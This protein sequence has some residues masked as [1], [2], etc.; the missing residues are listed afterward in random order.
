MNSRCYRETA[1]VAKEP[2]QINENLE[3]ENLEKTSFA[4]AA[5]RRSGDRRMCEV[6]AIV[7]DASGRIVK[8]S[9]AFEEATGRS[10]DYGKETSIWDLL[11]PGEDRDHADFSAEDLA[12]GDI[13]ERFET[14]L[15]L[16]E[17]NVQMVSWS[18]SV[19]MSADGSVDSV[20]S[21][22]NPISKTAIEIDAESE[23]SRIWPETKDCEF[24]QSRLQEVLE[25]LP[26]AAFVVD[27][28]RR[29]VLWNR[30][31]EEMTGVSKKDIIGKGN[32]AYS[33]PFYGKPRPALV[34]LLFSS[35]E[36]PGLHYSYAEK[37]EG[38]LCAEGPAP[39]LPGKKD[40]YIWIKATPILDEDGSL[41]GAIEL[42]R[43][44][45]DKKRED[46]AMIK[47]DRLLAGIAVATNCLLTMADYDSAMQQA[48]ETLGLASDVDRVCI[49]EVS[50]EDGRHSATQKFEW[51]RE[52]ISSGTCGPD[53]FD[54]LL[55]GW[56]E[57]LSSGRPVFWSAPGSGM[58]D[59]YRHSLTSQG[60]LTMVVVPI[61]I[62]DRFWG[63]IS[64][65]DC[66]SKR[67][68]LEPEVYMLLAAAGSV[69]GAIVRRWM[70]KALLESEAKNQSF[71]K[72]VPDLM[73]QIDREGTILDCRNEGEMDLYLPESEFLGRKAREV[74]PPHVAELIEES[75][76][77]ALKTREVQVLDY[78]LEVAGSISHYEARI[79]VSSENTFLV[80]VRNIT[81]S[82]NAEKAMRKAKEAAES[83][84]RAKSEFLANMSHEIRTPMNAVIGMT[85]LLME[86][87]L[88]EEQRDFVETIRQSGDALLEIINDIL[89]LSKIEGKRI[90]LEKRTFDL[91]RCIEEAVD[92]IAAK[93]SEKGLDLAYQIDDSVPRMILGDFT[94]LRQVLVNLLSNA[95]K[96]TDQGEITISVSSAVSISP[97]SAAQIP[98]C[99]VATISSVPEAQISSAPMAPIS[100]APMA[101][102]SFASADTDPFASNSSASLASATSPCPDYAFSHRLLKISFQIRDTG[103]G[104]PEESMSKLFRNFSQVDTSVTRKYGGT[105]L[106]LAISK[107][108]VEMMGGNIWADSVPGKGSKFHF[109]I[110]AEEAGPGSSCEEDLSL[111]HGRSVLV[112]DDGKTSTRILI[113]CLKRWGM[114]ASSAQSC[115]EALAWLDEGNKFDLAI[116]NASMD[117][118]S[119]LAEAIH[120]S[121]ASLILLTT[122]G[123][124]EGLDAY[125]PCLALTLPI[126][127]SQLRSTLVSILSKEAPV[128]SALDKTPA[129]TS[130]KTCEMPAARRIVGSKA[131]RIL[132]AEDNM[133][134]QKVALRMLEMIG[135]RADAVANGLEVLQ[136]L[137]RQR[138]DVV[139]MDVQMPDMDGLEATKRIRQNFP[140]GRQP[141]IIAMTACA[142]DGDEKRCIDAG[143]E[144]YISKPVKAEE[145]RTKLEAITEKEPVS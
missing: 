80:I 131:A 134:N 44:I 20:V 123:H 99:S 34:D 117:G 119:G 30:S 33:I 53:D 73:F 82:K 126:K 101:P 104:I 48:V 15:K 130:N 8:L 142:M 65:Q 3:N 141:K 138:Y 16:K 96:F 57:T 89:D 60:I 133:V 7:F 26:D 78:P 14:S 127:P 5:S 106:G 84:A 109:T 121:P 24:A 69:G 75:M 40:A 91:S 77:R 32:Q 41:I 110:L 22:G 87:S 36:A 12:K 129:R 102:I 2:H 143:M 115:H 64:F 9:R 140:T 11:Y 120:S 114:V 51:T 25:A 38:A 47:R 39:A 50:S 125:K 61:T 29:V 62:D 35:R 58:K 144:G 71:L 43:D 135:Y 98:P 19:F 116:L 1:E 66:R 113:D 108:L 88:T 56:H 112:L 70:E 68:W 107:N 28:S 145:L 18:N 124:P 100:S 92:L 31:M 6:L 97:A 27:S 95:V 46:E 72:A 93:A 45:T 74:L 55:P 118:S 59:D 81:E 52:E 137:E 21:T 128:A 83:A 17:G 67:E 79:A 23:I 42:V 63:F 10:L 13:P 37:A 54:D 76:V 85:S 90:E 105:G 103:I 111:L 136:A 86:T 4:S 122:L 94:R 132:L 139:L 49:F